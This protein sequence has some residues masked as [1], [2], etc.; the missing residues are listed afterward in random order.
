M[1]K[2]RMVQKYS[3]KQIKFILF[4]ND[5][6]VPPKEGNKMKYPSQA[7]S[8]KFYY[9]GTICNRPIGIFS[10]GFSIMYAS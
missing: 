6:T 4:F 10:G 1:K 9:S 2:N 8:S 3:L 7:L 5:N